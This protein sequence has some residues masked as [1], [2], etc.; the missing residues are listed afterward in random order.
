MVEVTRGLVYSRSTSIFASH[1]STIVHVISHRSYV[2]VAIN[3]HE[4]RGALFL[5]KPAVP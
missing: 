4:V 2:I 1:R 5:D 3:T